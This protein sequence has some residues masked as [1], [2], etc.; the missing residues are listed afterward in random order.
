MSE[1]AIDQLS[2]EF[3][4]AYAEWLG[5]T[6][7][8]AYDLLKN[9]P[10]TDVT[11]EPIQAAGWDESKHP[12]HPGGST[13]GGEF[14]PKG[15]PDT[16]GG[17]FAPQG[18][19]RTPFGTFGGEVRFEGLKPD[20]ELD[21]KIIAAVEDEV[22]R[23]KFPKDDAYYSITS[24]HRRTEALMAQVRHMWNA[25]DGDVQAAMRAVESAAQWGTSW[26]DALDEWDAAWQ[27][28]G[29]EPPK[30]IKK[31]L[32]E[33]TQEGARVGDYGQRPPLSPND[34]K[35]YAARTEFL[36][37]RFREAYPNGVQ[38]YRGITGKVPGR[39]WNTAG[40]ES[41]R[42]AH[43]NSKAETF[44]KEWYQAASD[45]IEGPVWP[46]SSWTESRW[47]ADNFA[48]GSKGTKSGVILRTDITA[49]DI[50]LI[51]AMGG[52][53]PIRYEDVTGEYVVTTPS[54]KRKARLV[55]SNV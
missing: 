49:D 40:W 52:Q 13:E 38:V 36:Q 43:V 17:K 47:Q 12:R 15:A 4:A 54:G 19:T 55:A 39:P 8:E 23:G 9:E 5:V 10:L 7:G 30:R 46:L 53:G 34:L 3:V 22:R 29:A 41:L 31:L 2:P 50:W 45:V 1:Q 16:V 11:D 18:Q 28:T 27:L 32:A 21:K 51:P 24:P 6:D 35:A 26:G 33:R 48:F 37:A 25:T 44:S 42:A 14:A 20:P